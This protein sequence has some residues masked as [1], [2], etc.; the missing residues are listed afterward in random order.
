MAEDAGDTYDYETGQY[1]TIDFS[2]DDT[3]KQLTIGARS[4]TFTGMLA[5]RTFNVVFVG[6]NHGNGHAVT[7]TADKTVSYDGTQ[8]VVAAP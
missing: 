7:A 2:W 6:A 4:G 1:A 3:A 5:T 8:T